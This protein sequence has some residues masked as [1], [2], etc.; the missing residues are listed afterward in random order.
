MQGAIVA[1]K[2]SDGKN[3]DAGGL[4][5]QAQNSTINN[6]TNLISITTSEKDNEK[7][8]ASIGGI[9]GYSENTTFNFCSNNA[10]IIAEKT[11]NLGGIVG[12]GQGVTI[13][14]SYNTAGLTL[15]YTGNKNLDNTGTM[16]A[17]GIVGIIEELKK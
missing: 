14:N 3:N 16:Y 4:S 17:G 11:D 9:V 12:H 1:T 7:V 10:T 6:V 15:N 8:K 5:A 13:Q 2:T